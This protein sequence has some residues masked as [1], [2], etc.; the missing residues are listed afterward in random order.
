MSLTT[1]E[2]FCPNDGRQE[3]PLAVEHAKDGP[4]LY[5][6]GCHTCAEAWTRRLA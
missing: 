1:L 5:W 6:Y 4:V 2:S 3:M